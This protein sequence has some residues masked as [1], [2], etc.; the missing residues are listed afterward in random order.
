MP[1]PSSWRE[2]LQEI[3]HD[4]LE[5][6]RIAAALKVTAITLRRWISGES[7]PRIRT[8]RQLQTIIPQS[9]RA[10]FV[11]FLQKEFGDLAP[12][13]SGEVPGEIAYT[14]IRQIFETRATT[15]HNLLFWTLCKKVLQQAL[16]HLDP[17]R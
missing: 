7:N 15:Q 16:R 3:I 8:L 14:F 9:R 17:E 5:R 11:D 10:L 2:V 4:P 1:T 13:W 6:D 12:Q